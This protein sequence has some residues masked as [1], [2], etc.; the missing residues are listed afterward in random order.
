MC[1]A[2]R[3]G[4][5]KSFKT[6]P[7]FFK[8]M[9]TFFTLGGLGI[10]EDGKAVSGW[11]SRKAEALLVYLACT[12]R[13]HARDALAALFWEDRS[14]AR[15][16]GNLSVLLTSLRKQVGP[17][18]T[19]GRSS[20]AMN[21]QAEIWVDAFAFQEEAAPL[22]REATL[23]RA[24]LGQLARAT[25]RYA[26]DF[27]AGFSVRGAPA[28]EEWALFEQ[29]RL[30]RLLLACLQRLAEACEVRG[31][32]AEGVV[33]ARRLVNVDPLHEPGHRALMRLLAQNGEPAAA[34]A[35]YEHCREILSAELGVEPEEETQALYTALRERRSLPAP[36]ARPSTPGAPRQDNLPAAATAFLG[37]EAERNL[38]RQH[39]ANP[40]CRLL[41]LVGPGGVGKSRLALEAAAE[42][43]GRFLHGVWWVP[44]AALTDAAD[45]PRAVAAALGLEFDAAA[46]PLEQLTAYLAQRDLLLVL[47][48]YE[49]F[50]DTGDLSLI[51]AILSRAPGV[52]L[53]VTSR[54]RLNAQA[55]WLLE[56]FG[57]PTPGVDQPLASSPAAA[58]F[59]ERAARLRPDVAANDADA[60]AVARICRLVSGLPLALELA[61]AWVRVLPLPVIADQ[62]E[63]DLALLAVSARDL[64]PRHRSMEAVL[65]SAWTL[66][67]P[68]RRDVL[69]RLAV[70]QGGAPLAGAQAV[71]H[72]SL[73]A[74]AALVDKS[75]LFLDEHGRYRRHPLVRQYT[76]TR[77]AQDPAE[78]AETRDRHAGFYAAFLEE[79]HRRLSGPEQIPALQAIQ[80]EMDNIRVAWRWAVHRGRW[81]LVAAMLDGLERFYDE[82]SLHLEAW[83][84]F[85]WAVD[86]LEA[87]G[88]PGDQQRLWVRLGLALG[89]HGY[90]LSR[91]EAARRRLEQAA[92]PARQ[93][94]WRRELA[95]ILHMQ[96][97]LRDDAGDYAGAT[98]LLEE[99]LTVVAGGV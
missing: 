81:D 73:P 50:L 62:L 24:G 63:R 53:L 10:E 20:I 97:L 93:E 64:P 11:A 60:Q 38:I 75:F 67:L 47:D 1:I 70:F 34:L 23:T 54:E 87:A 19:I 46:P 31:L 79:A 40:A 76:R 12:R 56:L 35:H 45:L 29:E 36:G 58:L 39:L 6:D 98:A 9:L 55:E 13:Q 30:Q 26:G 32:Y 22:L 52:K 3:P 33:H 51:Q 17:Y 96:A 41:S 91:Y 86:R 27:L 90:R 2:Y 72:A 80:L 5:S 4:L 88:P 18:V 21:W 69:R 43:R 99:A 49:Q 14:Q 15:A 71:A 82:R 44:L 94:G 42:Q 8:T 59:L 77:L 85:T 16:L 28:F 78:E 74:L 48:N 66:L 25:E 84:L 57:L 37:R 61:A 83:E 65:D 89:T 68:A 95:G 7:A 92:V